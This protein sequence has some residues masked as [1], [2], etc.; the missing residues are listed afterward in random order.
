MTSDKITNEEQEPTSTFSS[1]ACNVYY[2]LFLR[3]SRHS[4]NFG[5]ERFIS[6][7]QMNLN[8]TSFHPS[9]DGQWT[10]N[11][12]VKHL[13]HISQ[14]A[15][16]EPQDATPVFRWLNLAGHVAT[17]TSTYDAKQYGI[18]SR[19]MRNEGGTQRLLRQLGRNKK[20][21]WT[22]KQDSGRA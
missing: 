22:E 2:Q 18:L 5:E 3:L 15:D 8:M 16:T 20:I 7:P 4:C 1:S 6:Y 10:I 21:C 17:K 14:S 13:T 9:K 19:S 11:H 12:I